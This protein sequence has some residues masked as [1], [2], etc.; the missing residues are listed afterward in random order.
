MSKRTNTAFWYQNS[1]KINVQK[2]GVRRSFYS[3]KS[4]RTG[5]R[6]A[7]A[8][9]DAWLNDDIVTGGRVE[10]HWRDFLDWAYPVVPGSPVSAGRKKAEYTGDSYLLPYL[11]NLK[12]DKVTEGQLQT[13][14]N[15]AYTQGSFKK[16]NHQRRP[17]SLPLSRKTLMNI[18]ADIVHF[19]KYCRRIICVTTLNPEDLTIPK[20]ARYKG[21]TILQPE[22]LKVLFSVDTTTMYGKVLFDDFIYAYRFAV[23]CGL[24]P[25]ELIG[26]HVGDINKKYEL[27]IRRSINVDGVETTG[28]NENALRSIVLPQLA[29]DAYNAQ[30]DLLRSSGIEINLNTPLFQISNQHTFSNRW[31]RY[32][33]S[34]GLPHI[35]PYELRHTLVSIAKFLPAGQVKA[36]VGHSKSMDTFDIYGHLLN[37]EAE[38]TADDL[39]EI[40]DRIISLS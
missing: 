33:K 3:G 23:V 27:K 38:K 2:D 5:Q 19:F 39:S 12:I 16:D 9:A 18:R 13:L 30:I 8:K 22:N 29:R 32:L 34:N 36:I 26:I 17:A 31:A 6:E 20:G 37:G 25:G 15:K 28:K 35:S 10:K 7:N 1:W 4:G 40:F 14:L 21:K 11:G 24:R